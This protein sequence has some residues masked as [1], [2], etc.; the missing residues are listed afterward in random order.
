MWHSVHTATIYEL[1]A[2]AR[3]RQLLTDVSHSLIND[4][5]IAIPDDSSSS[6][7]FE[8]TS[9]PNFRVHSMA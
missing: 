1:R 3:Q 5:V 8:T 6:F 4:G 7:S 2:E 9:C